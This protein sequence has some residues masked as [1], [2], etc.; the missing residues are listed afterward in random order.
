MR[1]YQWVYPPRPLTPKGMIKMAAWGSLHR[2]E[3]VKLFLTV[4][5]VTCICMCVKI[6]TTMHQKWWILVMIIKNI[7]LKGENGLRYLNTN[8]Y[9]LFIHLYKMITYILFFMLNPNVS[10]S[11]VVVL[12]KISFDPVLANWIRI[13]FKISVTY[14]RWLQ[15]EIH[16]WFLAKV[17]LN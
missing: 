1:T 14:L 11:L 6:H 9:Q 2:K 4:L 15:T 3:V 13:N 17:H 5:L 16:E 8:E 10:V 12:S 7:N